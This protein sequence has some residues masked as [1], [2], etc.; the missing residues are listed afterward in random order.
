[1]METVTLVIDGLLLV[2]LGAVL[3]ACFMV[4]RRL[5]TM[6]DG[7]SELKGLVERLDG[8]TEEAQASVNELKGTSESAQDNLKREVAKARAL[9]DELT[10]ITEAGDNLATRLEQRLSGLRAANEPGTKPDDEA[11]NQGNDPAR[12]NL[13]QALREAR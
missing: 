8:L 5:R 13:M 12:T 9:A 2:L 6:R 4:N 11:F 3:V 1:M 7:Q 10:L